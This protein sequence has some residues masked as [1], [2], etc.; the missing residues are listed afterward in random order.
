MKSRDLHEWSTRSRPT[1]KFTVGCITNVLYKVTRTSRLIGGNCRLDSDSF[2]PFLN[3]NRFTSFIK[4]HSS[5]QR[6]TYRDRL[7]FFRCL[8]KHQGAD[9]KKNHFEDE[10]YRLFRQYIGTTRTSLSD[11]LPSLFGGV[12]LGDLTKMEEI[13]KISVF[14]YDV[15]DVKNL[16]PIFKSQSSYTKKIHLALITDHF[17]LITNFETLAGIYCCPNCQKHFN[18]RR[19][20]I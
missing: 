14:V 4:D 11:Q 19:H 9:H 12:S 15:T 3:D 8:A 1:T 18:S 6:K 10:V 2:K 16:I 7:C 17:M 5:R 13:F 20:I